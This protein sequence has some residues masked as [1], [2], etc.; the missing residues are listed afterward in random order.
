MSTQQTDIDKDQ[1]APPQTPGSFFREETLQREHLPPAIHLPPPR[2]P[3]PSRRNSWFVVAA[4][5]VALGLILSV[6][7]F[8]VSLQG[9]HPATQGTPTL[10]TRR[11][12][13][14]QSYDADLCRLSKVGQT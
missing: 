3:T 2:R 14:G 5:I 1:Q 6:F 4:V 8:V 7:A 11:E 9:Q 13:G 12:A 10:D